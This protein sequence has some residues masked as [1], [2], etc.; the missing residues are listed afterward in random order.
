MAGNNEVIN[1]IRN[2]K[3]WIRKKT[4]MQLCSLLEDQE[5]RLQ[6]VENNVRNH[7]R[8]IEEHNAH[9]QMIGEDIRE[10]NENISQFN[11]QIENHT[12]RM[13]C[14]EENFRN[15][16]R[17]IEEHITHHE[18][19]ENNI[20]ENNRYIKDHGIH[21]EQIERSRG[22]YDKNVE[23]NLD[24]L[25]RENRDLIKYMTK[26]KT[27]SAVATVGL[28]NENVQKEEK[29]VAV[30]AEKTVGSEY[31]GIDYFDFE[32][33]FRG[34]R[35]AIKKVQ[36]QYLKY[37]KGK[38]QVLDLGC[39]RGEFLELLAEHGIGAKGVDFYPEYVEY[40]KMR[41]LDVIC[42]D[43]IACLN[44]IDSVDGIFAG[45]L[46]EHLTTNQIIRLCELAYEKL[47]EDS[48]LII[49]TPNPTS[50]AIYS[51]A[52]YMDPSHIKPVHPLT[53][54]YY[55][56][57]AGFQHTEIIYT[58]NSKLP[59]TIPE[60]KIEGV[61]NLEM[62]NAAMKQVENALFGSQDY[63]IVAKR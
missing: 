57:K 7:N 31:N 16:N 13:Q 51:H 22:E 37:Y 34:S 53:L 30:P 60:L 62:F 40:C 27:D 36:E 24:E 32:D 12:L 61:E 49:E 23:K 25:R 56:Q 20:R 52:F 10:I 29:H 26:M 17:Y 11:E 43:A 63:A 9:H 55:L 3:F 2:S 58:E 5:R 48:Y 45:Q 41:N 54:N 47:T 39:G 33:H 18:M 46:V 1:L 4:K 14:M 6:A 8:Y 21:H 42:G 35:E 15:N 19:I 38:K 44:D 59:V 50:L 28:E